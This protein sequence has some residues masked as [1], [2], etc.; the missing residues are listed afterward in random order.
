M[1]V[2][3]RLHNNRQR[4]FSASP[5]PGPGCCEARGL[6]AQ[7]P[8]GRLRFFLGVVV[9]SSATARYKA[10]ARL[11]VPACAA[12]SRRPPP[13]GCGR[14]GAGCCFYE[15]RHCARSCDHSHRG[16]QC[17]RA[18]V[19][20]PFQVRPWTGLDPGRGIAATC[21]GP[22]CQ[23][24]SRLAEAFAESPLELGLPDRGSTPG[25]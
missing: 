10:L 22:D 16:S 8:G 6:L 4:R 13:T 9:L 7:L 21:R 23:R 20:L 11:R 17:I 15:R 25:A 24:C 1:V 2:V 18:E 5:A 19:A 14:L 12:A 3:A